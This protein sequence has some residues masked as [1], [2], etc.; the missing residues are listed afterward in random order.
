MKRNELR[1]IDLN[2][3]VVFETLIQECNLTRAGKRLSLGQPAVSAALIRL[4]R[5]FNDPLFE[6]NGRTM[7]PT[8]RALSAAQMLGP[9]LDSVCV[10][11]ADT[12]G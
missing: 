9:A 5:L 11:L 10:A 4:R 7:V 6:R 8:P 1:S 3:L 2:L 12:K